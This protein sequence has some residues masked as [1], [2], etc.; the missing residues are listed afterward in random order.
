MYDE[1]EVW[2]TIPHYEGRYLVSNQGRIFSLLKNRIMSVSQNKGY[3]SIRLVGSDGK[4]R[5]EAVHRLVALAFLDNPEHKPEVNHIN[6]IRS[7]NRVENLEWVSRRENTEHRWKYL[8]QTKVREQSRETM[9]Q[10]SRD[11]FGYNP[12]RCVETGEVFESSYE[13]ELAMKPIAPTIHCEN[14]RQ[15]CLGK[16]KTSGGYHWELINNTEENTHGRD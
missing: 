5:G 3:L 16:R 12:V 7:D 2:R 15:C 10:I 11:R 14:I 9:K 4:R 13:A 1:E 8:D 6:G